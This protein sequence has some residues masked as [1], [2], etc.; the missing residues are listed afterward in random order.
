MIGRQNRKSKS[1][2]RGVALVIALLTLLLISAIL[3]GMIVASNS[4]TNISTNFRDEQT[5]FFAARAGIEEIRDRLRASAPNTLTSTAF[6]TTA[7]TPLPGAV[8]GVLYITNP[9]GGE[10]VTP[11]LTTGTNYPDDEICKEV[12]CV[13]GIPAGAWAL[14][15]QSAS[16]SYAATPVLPWKWV[17]IMIKPNKSDTGA[18][19]VT[20]VDGQT[21]GNRVCFNG[22]NE[23]T[24]AATSCP[25]KPVYELT[26]LAVTKSGSRRMVQ[27]EISQSSLP[28][29]PGAMVFDGA[30][31]NFGTNPNSAAFGVTG[32]DTHTGPN[33][34]A[35]CPAASNEPALGGFDA[36]STTSLQS[37]VNRPGSY[38]GSPAGI[39]NVSSQL[40]PLS[41][42]AGL[43]ALVSSITTMAGANVYGASP[44]P[45]PAGLN[46]G[47]NASPQIN[48][49]EGDYTMPG[50]G[51]GILLVTG[52]LTMN[53]NP[54]WNGLIL[55]VG[56]GS[57]VKNGGGNGTLDGALLVAN[58]YSDP[59]PTYTHLI[60]SG[61]PG[62]P[63]IAWN[64][65]GNATIQYDSCWLSFLSQSLPYQT[66]TD[67]ELIY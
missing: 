45:S 46:A 13:G 12:T 60:A 20:S 10:T 55:V 21:N 63:T 51:S 66:I 30:T 52:T 32:M 27:Y 5:A 42:V 44:L 6:F 16:A 15:A 22:T 18:V 48:V 35:G 31:P 34:G 67:R 11:W 17:R 50:S 40:G 2:E 3:M 36:A 57:I 65:G 54:S 7:P 14:P 8:N 9:T 58:L 37:Q 23:H 53:G 39:S 4:E 29:I 41:T 28:P 47:T 43:D 64:G 26:S 19:R 25:D 62:I 1:S 24:T 38:A 49:V 59:P 56:K 61:A 33:G